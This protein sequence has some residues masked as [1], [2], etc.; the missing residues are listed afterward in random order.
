MIIS[1]DEVAAEVAA[2]LA[3]SAPVGVR[4]FSVADSPGCVQV[5]A[6]EARLSGSCQPHLTSQPRL[7][8]S[9]WHDEVHGPSGS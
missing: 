7:A 9:S 4:G 3:A 2:A 8:Y 6:A 1:F 5:T